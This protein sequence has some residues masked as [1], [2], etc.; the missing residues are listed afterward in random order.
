MLITVPA[1]TTPQK[2]SITRHRSGSKKGAYYI[3]QSDL[4]SSNPISDLLRIVYSLL[5]DHN[6]P[7]KVLVLVG[8]L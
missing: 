5:Y 1:F 3:L 4:H 7:R 8:N 6:G 2:V